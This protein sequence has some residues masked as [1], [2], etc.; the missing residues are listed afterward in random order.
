MIVLLM[1]VSSVIG[2]VDRMC[3]SFLSEYVFFLH[4]FWPCRYEFFDF[5]LP[6]GDK[7]F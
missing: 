3:Q 5:S 2:W 4:S 6:L 1:V 7:F